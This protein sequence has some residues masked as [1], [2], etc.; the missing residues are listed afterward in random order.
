ME[1]RH[2]HPLLR[3]H[4]GD[5]CP[6][7]IGKNVN[8]FHSEGKIYQGR[9]VGTPRQ[10]EIPRLTTLFFFSSILLY[11]YKPWH[12]VLYTRQ[13]PLLEALHLIKVSYMLHVGMYGLMVLTLGYHI[14]CFLRPL[15]TVNSLRQAQAS[16][17]NEKVTPESLGKDRKQD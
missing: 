7:E 4:E 10:I 11:L 14:D 12:P 6:T 3:R 17:S 5:Q 15:S 1:I 13:F 8:F 9:K 16:T 2:Q